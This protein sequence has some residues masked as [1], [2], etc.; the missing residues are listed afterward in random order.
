MGFSK[1]IIAWK[2][3]TNMRAEDVME[4]LNLALKASGC[5]QATRVTVGEDTHVNM[6]GPTSIKF[7]CVM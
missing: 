7:L 5:D 1:Y 4:T 6:F 2:L 3:C